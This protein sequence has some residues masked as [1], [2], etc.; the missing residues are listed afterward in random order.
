M[1][2]PIHGYSLRMVRQTT[3]MLPQAL[4][5][6]APCVEKLK[7]HSVLSVCCIGIEL[8]PTNYSRSVNVL[9]YL[10]TCSNLTSTLS[11]RFSC[12]E[13]RRRVTAIGCK[14]CVRTARLLK[15]AAAAAVHRPWLCLVLSA[16][17]SGAHDSRLKTLDS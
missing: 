13:C 9:D 7:L 15:E 10:Q 12:A 16:Q 2:P 8:A 14:Y 17:C 5:M 6:T 3:S 11:H 4:V 1:N